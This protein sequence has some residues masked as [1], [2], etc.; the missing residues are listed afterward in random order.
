MNASRLPSISEAAFGAGESKTG[1]AAATT[2]GIKAHMNVSRIEVLPTT[3]GGQQVVKFF[4][5]PNMK[6]YHLLDAHQSLKLE[7]DIMNLVHSRRISQMRH[8]IHLHSKLTKRQEE[9]KALKSV[10]DEAFGNKSKLFWISIIII[11]F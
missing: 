7:K 2:S 4:S 3:G 5:R 1:A 9:I 11:I 10:L 8:T 6:G